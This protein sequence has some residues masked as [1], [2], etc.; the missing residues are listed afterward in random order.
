MGNT[1]P[2]F[3]TQTELMVSMPYALKRAVRL[4]AA[5][6][7]IS[8]GEWIRRTL[9]HAVLEA[10]KRAAAD[11]LPSMAAMIAAATEASTLSQSV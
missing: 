2:V 8:M 6:D 4:Q 1:R 9:A 3:A 11:A 5:R 10:N 7:D